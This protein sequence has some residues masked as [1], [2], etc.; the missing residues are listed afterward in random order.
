MQA[1][2]A[3]QD[4]PDKELSAGLGV[5]RIFQEVPFHVSASVPYAEEPTATHAAFEAQ[6]TDDSELKGEPDGLG[7][8]G[9]CQV[10]PFQVSAN[11]SVP[12]GPRFV[13][14]AVHVVAPRQ[15]TPDR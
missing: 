11:V 12:L 9:I 1:S 5:S 4:T 7:V 3:G 15:D 13:P 10:L 2:A 6:D 8:V 14:T